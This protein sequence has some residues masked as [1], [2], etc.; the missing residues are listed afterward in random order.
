MFDCPK[1]RSLGWQNRVS[2]MKPAQIAAV[3]KTFMRRG[4]FKKQKEPKPS[5]DYYQFTIFDLMEDN[6]NENG[7]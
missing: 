7:C 6:K 4:Y 2:R 1:Y 5:D 3:Y